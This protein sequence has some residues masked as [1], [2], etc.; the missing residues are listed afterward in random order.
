[1]IVTSVIVMGW[2]CIRKFRGD[3]QEVPKA[4][5]RDT[6]K[7]SSGRVSVLSSNNIAYKSVKS[8]KGSGISNKDIKSEDSEEFPKE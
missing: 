8:I 5:H 6:Y 2:L 3:K 4:H 1:V 7:L